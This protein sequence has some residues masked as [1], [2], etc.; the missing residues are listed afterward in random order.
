[1]SRTRS[2]CFIRA[3]LLAVVTVGSPVFAAG[4][5]GQEIVDK[6]NARDQGNG[7]RQDLIMTLTDKSG[8]VQ[9]R[10]TVFLAKKV[11]GGA[12]SLIYFKDPAKLKG[13][14]FLT[15][16]FSASGEQSAQWLYL[17]SM[18]RTRRVSAAERGAY[19]LGTDFTNDDIKNQ[20]RIGAKDFSFEAGGEETI[21]GINTLLVD[22]KPNS[23]KIA[24]EVGYG[25]V[26]IAV[27]PKTWVVVR[28]QYW[29]TNQN[30]L[31]TTRLYDIAEI[32]GIMT[33][34]RIV[35]ENLKTG[36]KTEFLFENIQYNPALND[37]VFTEQGLRQ[38][39]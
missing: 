16:D 20:T 2:V 25:R 27:D 6:V 19:F 12:K 13:T 22:S 4:M 17:P 35:T 23:D 21:D 39:L 31:K 33:S 14:A 3:L 18:Q 9:V 8:D 32:Q 1:M 5:T 29:D 38:G 30:P 7:V 37:D 28:A 24:N 15:Y 26:R 34:Q 36:H 11:E 10:R